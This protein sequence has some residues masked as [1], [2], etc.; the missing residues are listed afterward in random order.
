MAGKIFISYRRDDAAGD[1]RGIRDALAAKFGRANVFMD[2]DNLLAGQR[3][4]KELSKALDAC[5]VLIAIIGPRWMELL[6]ARTQGGE[7][8]YVREEIGAALRRGIDVIPARVGLEGKM[9]VLP[10]GADLP[11]DIRDLILHQKHD[12][13]HERFG[14]DVTE[15]IEAIEAAHE[16]RRLD[17]ADLNPAPGAA[18]DPRRQP[19]PHLDVAKVS[20]VPRYLNGDEL[21]RHGRLW[22]LVATGL[23]GAIGLGS[24][25]AYTYKGLTAPSQRPAP[26]VVADSSPAKVEPKQGGGSPADYQAKVFASREEMPVD[27]RRE[28]AISIA[29]KKDV[30]LAETN[31]SSLPGTIFENVG[32]AAPS[33]TSKTVA[34]PSQ[35]TAA[36][37][38]SSIAPGTGY[39]AV[40]ASQ[41]TRTDVL[42]IFADLQGKYG[43]VLAGRTYDVKEANLGD[44]GVWYRLFIGPPGSQDTANAVCTELKSAG[45]N[46]CWVGQY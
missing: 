36:M 16:R 38:P 8:D 21:R 1:A 35:K 6:N 14:R 24:A 29:P 30:S 18:S 15:L 13:A 33:A 10:R 41:K 7:R 19:Q 4:D 9:P 39:V 20:A 34:P 40:V 32:P 28:T 17:A 43:R 23:I 2:I 37:A 31:L 44:K 46:G 45:Y 12:V 27:L 22:A 5:D 42:R 3:F 25:V 11:E 26:V